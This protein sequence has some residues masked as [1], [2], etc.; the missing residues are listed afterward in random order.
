MSEKWLESP[1]AKKSK[2][3]KVVFDVRFSEQVE[4][5]INV[6]FQVLIDDLLFNFEI[7]SFTDFCIVFYVQVISPLVKVLRIVDGD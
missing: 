5:I 7:L 2:A 6:S 3:E 4:E 1:Y